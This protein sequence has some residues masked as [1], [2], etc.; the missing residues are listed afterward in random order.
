MVV[1]RSRNHLPFPDCL[2]VDV[3]SDCDLMDEANG[4]YMDCTD[5]KDEYE[6]DTAL[7]RSIQPF[8]CEADDQALGHV[9][10]SDGSSCSYTCFPLRWRNELS[11]LCPST[12]RVLLD[13]PPVQ[14]DMRKRASYSTYY[15][16]VTT[17]T[18]ES[19]LAYFC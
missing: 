14:P 8:S 5:M 4:S 9:L 17:H 3:S 19:C 11:V 12:C 2:L 6:S 13:H 15:S 18:Y 1:I 10:G 7:I 16:A